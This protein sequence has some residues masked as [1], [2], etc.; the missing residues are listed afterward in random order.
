MIRLICRFTIAS[1]V[2]ILLLIITARAIGSTNKPHALAMLDPGNC[3]QPCWHGIQ[4]GMKVNYAQA[5]LHGDPVLVSV[6]PTL[7][8]KYADGVFAACWRRTL[9]TS[10]RGCI[11]PYH[12]EKRTQVNRIF[13]W[14][15]QGGFRLGDLINSFGEPIATYTCPAIDGLETT[16]PKPYLGVSILF[17]NGISALA[18]KTKD[19]NKQRI[20]PNMLIHDLIYWPQSENLFSNSELQLWRGFGQ[21]TMGSMPCGG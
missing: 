4:P 7:Q 19:P 9:D 10:W 16:L 18:Y 5:I 6:E 12:D 15:S 11:E 17:R 13:L 1:M 20:Y 2:L 8:G 21:L 14:P 3:P